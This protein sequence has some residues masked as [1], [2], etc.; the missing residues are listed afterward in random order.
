MNKKIKII[1]PV[2][3]ILLLLII[4][5]VFYWRQ[6]KKESE[7]GFVWFEKFIERDLNGEKITEDKKSGLSVKIPKEWKKVEGIGGLSIIFLSP[8]FEPHPKMGPYTPPIPEKGCSIEMSVKKEVPFS[9]SDIEYSYLQEK[10]EKCLELTGCEDE[11]I[12]IN[13][14]KAL[15]H[16]FSSEDQSFVVGNYVSVKIPSNEWIYTFKAYLFSQDKEKCAQEFD[17]F[18]GS[19]S[20]K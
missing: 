3:I 14:H 11:V 1:I 10:I 20:L 9:D 18:L 19:V 12:E 17:K 5:G 13:G 2:V 8:D 6:W 4:G 15:K 16:I 7:V